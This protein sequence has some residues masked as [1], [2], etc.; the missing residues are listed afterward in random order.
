MK[1]LRMGVL[2][3]MLAFAGVAHAVTTFDDNVT[4]DILFGSGNGNGGFTVDREGSVELGLRA[5]VRFPVPG[6]VFNSNGDGTYSFKAGLGAAPDH[7]LWAFEWSVNTDWNGMTGDTLS[8][9]TYLLEIDYDPGAG[10]DF[11]AWDHITAPTAP[12]P[13]TTPF[14]P[15]F[16]DHSIGTNATPNGGG[17]E[18]TNA[19]NYAPLVAGNNVAQNSW[20]LSFFNEP[21]FA[22]DPNATGTYDIRL[23]ALSGVTEVAQVTIKVLVDGDVTPDV[24]Y[25]GGNANGS[26][27]LA[28]TN[29]IELGLRGKL[30]FPP[31]NV[32][33]SNFDGT[34][35][36]ERGLGAGP[37]HPV[38]AFDW[39]VNTDWNGMSGDTLSD[40]TYLIELDYDP[41]AGTNFLAWDHITAPTAPV[42]FTTPFNPG[43]WDHSIGTNSTPNGGGTEATNASQYATL[44]AANNVAQ[45]SWRFSFF[46]EP[47]FSFDPNAIGRYDVRLTA[48]S[49]AT[50]AA[51]VGIQIKVVVSA[52]CTSNAQCDDGLACNGME[53]CNLSTSQCEFGT[54]VVCSGTCL[55]GACVEPTGTCQVAA[56]GVLCSDGL[57][58][59]VSDTC[60]GGVC[61][62]GAGG[63]ADN[64]G[65]C[66]SEETTC[67]CNPNDGAEIC[68]LPN[69]LVG[70]AG[71]AAGE[72]L[73]NWH[74]PTTS[75]VAVATD[76]S[77][78]Q[79][80]VCSA[81]RCTAGQI[82]D[83]CTTNADCNLAANTC[84]MI[85]NYGDISDLALN[86]AKVNRTDASA[87]FLPATP[88]CSR[89][90]DV[91][92][93]ATRLSNR[94]RTK[95]SG[96]IDG[97]PRRDRDNFSYR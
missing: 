73:L 14:N 58:C 71:N 72:V 54:P 25:G 48:L 79:S 10:T 32:F 33:N 34:Y 62:P 74:T 37:D 22:F 69:R 70:V 23:T 64:D 83:I 95:A 93:D 80:G 78:Q 86:F 30:R 26:F 65:D 21:P 87:L 20:R 49:G 84:R 85:V 55:T 27:T 60:Q 7:A 35:T 92:L 8:D 39:S 41:G 5:K 52:T 29:S 17:T 57:E 96:T 24:I 31:S 75:R 6:N 36:F 53:T 76:P 59:T 44:L 51:S 81:G 18:A 82:E 50:P 63:D 61:V 4:P 68:A 42:P 38:W 77:C 11:L 66:D 94:V 40:F 1:V 3:S 46:N 13:F 16:W 45:N 89:K 2:A 56:N 9:F 12:V 90:V 28:R 67:G 47:P 43:F 15:G 97:R 91:P 88:G 19:S